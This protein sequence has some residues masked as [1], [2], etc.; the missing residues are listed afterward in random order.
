MIEKL[1]V[2]D[3]SIVNLVNLSAFYL[4]ITLLNSSL[5]AITDGQVF[6]TL[7][8]PR[9][10]EAKEG[11]AGVGAGEEA[12]DGQEQDGHHQ[13][14]GHGEDLAGREGGASPDEKSLTVNGFKTSTAES[15]LHLT[16]SGRMCCVFRELF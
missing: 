3:L 6:G 12:D 14:H 13:P 16:V 15:N 10:L 4:F 11:K 7:D 2:I 5:E 1:I 9:P 8:H